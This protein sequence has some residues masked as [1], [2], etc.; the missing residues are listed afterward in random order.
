VAKVAEALALAARGFRV[1]PLVAHAKKPA[2][3]QFPMQATTD[4]ERIRDWFSDA[5]V[6]Y[7]IGVSTTGLVVIDV[8]TKKGPHALANYLANSGHWNTLVVKTASG[9]YHCYFAGPDSRLAVDLVPGV[10]IRSHGGYVVGPGSVTSV[11]HEGCVDGKYEIVND[12]PLAPVPVGFAILLQ[13]PRERSKQDAEQRDKASGISNGMIWLQGAEPAIQGQGGDVATYRI[14]AKLVRDFALTE[15]TA[16]QLMKDHWNH[17]C[18]PPWEPWELWAKVE[19]AG[20]YGTHDLGSALPERI[21][22]HLTIS[23]PGVLP[24]AEKIGVYMGNAPDPDKITPRPW[25]VRKLLMNGDVTVLGGMGAA[26][27]SM[28]QIVLAA[29]W[30]IGLSIDPFG[31]VVPA[32]PLRT[33][34]YNG[35]DDLMENARRLMAVCVHFGFNYQDVR[36]N[37]AFMDDRATGDLVV[38]AASRDQLIIHEPAVRFI[39]QTSLDEK[40]DVQMFDPLINLH[41]CD[42]NNNKHMSFV[43]RT[44]RAIARQCNTSVFIAHHIGK[45]SKNRDKGDVDLFRGA[46]ALLTSARIGLI[47]SGITSEDCSRYGIRDKSNYSRLDNAKA[48][49]F[50]PTDTALAYMRWNAQSI[51]TTD[52]IGVPAWVDVEKEYKRN[53]YEVAVIVRDA[54]VTGSTGGMKQTAV[55]T[56][57]KVKHPLYRD[58][59]ITRIREL[60]TEFFKL[61]IQVDGDRVVFSNENGD[62][63]FRLV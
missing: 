33:M 56:I 54:I 53:M 30:A 43:V 31:L 42:E 15:E 1:F 3:D 58:L 17:R 29:H 44:F 28:L 12:A 2:V 52:V 46:S 14:A 37:I 41:A 51:P 5:W 59:S 4:P 25:R 21:F 36:R 23:E 63:M 32:M 47:M 50:K 24:T 19:N 48:N 40:V 13:P 26:G 57:L 62:D 60:I 35:E 45:G 49:M 61:P 20:A 8:D 7:N 38:A 9:G 39:V 11:F 55:A 10:D 6:D 16:F 34:I 18:I 22:G 27:K